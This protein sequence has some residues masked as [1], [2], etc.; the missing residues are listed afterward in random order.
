MLSLPMPKDVE[1]VVCGQ[2][3]V[4]A[5]AQKGHIIVDTSTVDPFSTRK[6]A[7]I[8]KNSGIGYIDA[9]VLGRPQACGTWTLP[10]GGDVSV[11]E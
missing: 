1:S 10:I 4:L 3:G 5:G 11:M 2:D 6:N 7:E 8:A 9:S